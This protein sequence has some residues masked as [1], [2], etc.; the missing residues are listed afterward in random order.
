VRYASDLSMKRTKNTMKELTRLV[1]ISILM[2]ALSGVA[3]ADGGETEGPPLA[4]PAP[5]AECT[6]DCSS[7]AASTPTQPTQNPTVDIITTAEMFATWL[8]TSIL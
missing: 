4:P 2:V 7:T 3:L 1:A 8:A 6:T 5:P